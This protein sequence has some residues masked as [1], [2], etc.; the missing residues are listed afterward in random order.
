MVLF[1]FS[2]KK[3]FG[4][5]PRLLNKPL[6]FITKLLENSSKVVLSKVLPTC[7]CRDYVLRFLWYMDIFYWIQYT[8][9]TG[10]RANCTFGAS[11]HSV[12]CR[13]ALC[14]VQVSTLS[15]CRCAPEVGP[16]PDYRSR[17]QQDSAFFFRIRIRSRSQKFESLFRFGSS[18]SLCSHSLGKNMGKLR[19]DRWL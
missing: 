2:K 5:L 19:L 15:K 13:C 6:G 17:L 18:R 9:Q 8:F 10:L 11:A 7:R 16:D 1:G 3:L 14:R 4:T 12:R